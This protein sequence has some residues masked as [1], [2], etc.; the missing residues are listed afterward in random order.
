MKK[1]AAVSHR[2]LPEAYIDN[3]LTETTCRAWFR[4]FKAGDFDVEDKERPG[5]P[6]MF[7]DNELQVLL[8]E[9]DAQTQQEL[10]EQIGVAR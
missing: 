3:A 10:A 7:Q 4:R 1:T 2:M 8:D 9:N 6:K 5:H